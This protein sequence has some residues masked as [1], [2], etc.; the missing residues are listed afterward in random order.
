VAV[1]PA[2]T[3]YGLCCDPEDPAAVERIYELKGRPPQRPSA[4]MFFSLTLALESL[5]ELR[6]RE[7]AALSAL[8]PG[9]VTLLLANPRR[10]Y[11]PACGPDPDTLG[12]RVPLL[13]GGLAAL[14][15]VAVPVM[16]SSANI[17]G[18][19]DARRLQD[20]PE[21][22]RRG[23]DLLLDGGDLPG[24]PSTVVDLRDYAEEGTWK[25]LRDGALS[26]GE[27]SQLLA[28]AGGT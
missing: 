10:R 22:L 24:L 18:E 16:Q 19:A 14:G 27:L 5:T 25:V 17:S 15:A 3:V 28:R 9:P 7:R 6:P 26:A 23:V 8:L 20:V 11:G 12:L 21:R 4:I 2:D 13:A 1:F